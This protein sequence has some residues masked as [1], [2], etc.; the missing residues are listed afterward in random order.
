MQDARHV[1]GEEKKNND[2]FPFFFLLSRVSRL[3]AQTRTNGPTRREK[4]HIT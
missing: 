4:V 2:Y 1:M 3:A